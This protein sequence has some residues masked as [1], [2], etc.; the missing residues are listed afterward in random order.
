[1]TLGEGWG[2]RVV[3]GYHSLQQP[4]HFLYPD[5]SERKEAKTEESPKGGWG[6]VLHPRAWV[7]LNHG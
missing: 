2:G 3:N 1:M 7:R 4:N 6:E 5:H